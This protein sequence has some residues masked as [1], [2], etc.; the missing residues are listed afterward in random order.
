MLFFPLQKENAL[1]ESPTG[2][3]KT[4]SLLCSTLAWLD[5]RKYEDIE[6]NAIDI[7]NNKNYSAIK[8]APENDDPNMSQKKGKGW[9]NESPI[10]VIYSSR[11]HSQLNQACAELKRSYYRYC[12]SVTIGSRDQL[13]INPEV[14][15]LES[16]SAKNQSCR[17]KVKTN[18]CKFHSNYEQ[19]VSDLSFSGSSVYDIE[20]L[21]KFGNE[22]KACP[23]YIAKAKTDFNTQLVFMPYNYILDPSIRKTLKLNLENAII[24]FDEGHNIER[25]C[26]EAM[27]KELKAEWLTTFINSFDDVLKSLHHLESGNYDGTNER[28]LSKLSIHDV[29]MVKVAICDLERELDLMIR[30]DPKNNETYHKTLD[31]F[32]LFEKIKLDSNKCSLVFSVCDKLVNYVMTDTTAFMANTIVNAL[33][34]VCS[35]IESIVPFSEEKEQK[36]DLGKYKTE[37]IR[38]YRLFSKIETDSGSGNK[39]WGRKKS[40]NAWTLNLW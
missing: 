8:I 11:T 13:C 23:Y 33:T 25:V 19:K 39:S 12:Q 36:I 40:V 32:N 15:K 16:I 29:A 1:L 24:I 21:I 5:N 37:F 9:K 31:I 3:G 6:L 4:L 2:T 10:R 27:S 20:D 28:E 7:P 35:F 14:T 18:T 22:H 17:M 26:E 34:S 38:T 30:Q